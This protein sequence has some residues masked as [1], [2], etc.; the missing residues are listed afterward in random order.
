VYKLTNTSYFP[1][2]IVWQYYPEGENAAHRAF[3]SFKTYDS[4]GNCTVD[5]T[6]KTNIAFTGIIVQDDNN[7]TV[8]YWTYYKKPNYAE[9][10]ISWLEYPMNKSFTFYTTSGFPYTAYCAITGYGLQFFCFDTRV[11]VPPLLTNFNIVFLNTHV[12]TILVGFFEMYTSGT[13]YNLYFFMRYVTLYTLTNFTVT[14]F[15]DSNV[16]KLEF[17]PNF[18]GYI[19]IKGTSKNY[20][21]NFTKDLQFYTNIPYVGNEIEI[22]DS[23]NTFVYKYDLTRFLSCL[24]TPESNLYTI[25]LKD[26]NGNQIYKFKIIYGASEYSSDERG[27][28]SI[29]PLNNANITVIPLD[30]TDLAFST[31]VTTDKPEIWITAP[32]YIYTVQLVV[33]QQTIIGTELPA[34][35]KFF[36]TG[37][38][39]MDKQNLTNDNF[40][41][42]N[43]AYDNYTVQLLPGN[44]QIQF[45]TVLYFPTLSVRIAAYNLSLFDNNY[46]RRILWKVGILGDSFN[47]TILGNPLLSITVID[48]NGKPVK[49]AEIQV[50]DQNNESIGIKLTDNNGNAQFYVKNGYNY[51]VKVYYAGN[52]KTVKEIEFPADETVIQVTIQISI[53]QQEQ[54]AVQSGQ[55]GQSGQTGQNITVPSP[56]EVQNQI[57]SILAVILTNYAIWAF[58]FIIIFAAYAAKMAGTEIGILVAIICIA[59][60]TFI[61]PWLPVQIIALIGVVAGILF[62]LRL[63]RR[64]Q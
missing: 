7:K 11:S 43:T 10:Y 22:Y 59:V 47:E 50:F 25:K 14:Y 63:V 21:F 40:T 58:V 48:Q 27:I 26:L 35:F 53:T 42:E 52:L 20:T 39:Y 46:Y 57:S 19:V 64:S 24:G 32:F 44:Y 28:V 45:R 49:S 13:T 15:K 33:R 29:L 16:I 18:N 5:N 17:I 3:V 61:V 56:Q 12:K 2:Y 51:T 6:W 54:Q 8:G 38:E 1:Q 37:Q 41:Y 60:F 31:T 9:M 30:R 62:G 34:A 4:N 23:L 36:I 55:S